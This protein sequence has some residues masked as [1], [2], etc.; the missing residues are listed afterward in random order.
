MEVDFELNATM[1]PIRYV[2]R[3]DSM[4]KLFDIVNL[5]SMKDE[6]KQKA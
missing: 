5:E 3:P 4:E 1:K 2:H 6:L